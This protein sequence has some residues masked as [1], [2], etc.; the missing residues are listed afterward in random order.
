VKA[1]LNGQPQVPFDDVTVPPTLLQHVSKTVVLPEEQ[2][3]NGFVGAR[4]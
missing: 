2:P 3:E 4:S 1:E